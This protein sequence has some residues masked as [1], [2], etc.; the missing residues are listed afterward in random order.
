VIVDAQT[1]TPMTTGAWGEG[2]EW[3]PP[4]K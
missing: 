3:R 4:F 1:M 2:D